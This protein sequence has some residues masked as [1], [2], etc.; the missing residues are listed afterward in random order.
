MR[1]LA[2]GAEK[3]RRGGGY[4]AV[5]IEKTEATK[6]RKETREDNMS[7]QPEK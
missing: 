7:K 5:T 1:Q 6:R 4:T 3:K 2:E